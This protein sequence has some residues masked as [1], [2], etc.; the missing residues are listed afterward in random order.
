MNVP[1]TPANVGR[2]VENIVADLHNSDFSDAN[3]DLTIDIMGVLNYTSGMKL[4]LTFVDSLTDEDIEEWR[5]IAIKNGASGIKTKVNTGSGLIDINIEYKG[6]TPASI[7]RIWLLRAVLLL[8]G[9]WS[10]QQLNLLNPVRYPS[11]IG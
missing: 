8:V 2:S 5:A 9:S 3:V 6:G 1:N 10:Y 7:N 4:R 11:P